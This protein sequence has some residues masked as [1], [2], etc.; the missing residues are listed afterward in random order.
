MS[1]RG[2]QHSVDPGNA[3]MQEYWGGSRGLSWVRRSVAYDGQLR[4][5]TDELISALAPSS[6][7]FALDVGCGTG[8][9][10]RDLATAV[11]ADGA[12]VGVDLSEAMVAGARAASDASGL[13]RIQHPNFEVADVQVADLPALN[14]GRRY[15]VI[16]SRFGVMFFADPDAAFANLAAATAEGGRFGFICW[17]SPDQNP[18]FTEPRAAA[19]PVLAAVVPPAAPEPPDAP[20]PFSMAEPDR[21]ADL[22]QRTGW[23]DVS[24]RTLRD[25]LYVGG[26][27]SVDAAIEFHTSGSGMAPTLEAHPELLEPMQAAL[28]EVL[29]PQHDGTGV[30]YPAAA[31]LVTAIR[32]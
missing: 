27:G 29:T 15:D 13:E 24:T 25:D 18:W 31:H 2:E 14:N 6:G 32:P 3:P 19:A 5:Y 10:T 21:V 12:A 16:A 9:T 30:R 20:G 22:L 11:G 26:P 17:A 28:L 4:P 23:A 7:E 1:D 8:F